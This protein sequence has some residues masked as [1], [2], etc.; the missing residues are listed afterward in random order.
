MTGCVRDCFR[1]CPETESKRQEAS[2]GKAKV[3]ERKGTG[4]RQTPHRGLRLEQNTP[5]YEVLHALLQVSSLC[6]QSSAEH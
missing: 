4:S 1:D 5:G 3:Q 6:K 2:P